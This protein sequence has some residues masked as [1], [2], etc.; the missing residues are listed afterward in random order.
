V[1]VPRIQIEEGELNGKSASEEPSLE[2]GL[3]GGTNRSA[4]ILLVLNT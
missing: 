4:I 1:E 2:G 3:F